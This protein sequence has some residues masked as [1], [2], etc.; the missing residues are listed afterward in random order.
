MKKFKKII[1]VV[2]AMAMT[3]AMSFGALAATGTD[4]IQ[5]TNTVKDETYN[6]YKMFDL[7]VNEDK[8]AFSYTVS[9]AWKTFFDEKGDGAKYIT[10]FNG[11]VTEI[12]DKDGVVTD[13]AKDLAKAATV[14]AKNL[15]PDKTVKATSDTVN[16][17]GLN[18]GYY[19]I[20]STLGTKAMIQTTPQASDVKINEK[21]PEDTIEK[22]V[23]E[24]STE[25]WGNKN[26][27][28]VGQ[29]VEFQSTAV[30][31]PNTRNVKIHDTMTLGLTFNKDIVIKNGET[32]LTETTDYTVAYNENNETFTVTFTDSYLN[33]LTADTTLT[34]TYSAVLNEN[35][36]VNNNITD[37]T[38]TTSIT[39]GDKQSVEDE[40]TT[41]THKFSVYKHAAGSTTNL[42]GAIFKVELGDGTVLQL[43]KLDDN[44]YRIAK[45]NADGT[46][47][48]GAVETFTTVAN[49]DIVIWGVDSDKYLLEET[50]APSGYNKL[51][52]KKEVV[53]DA[54]N[55]TRVDVENTTG[56]MLPT[57]GGMGT[58]ILYVAGAILVIAGA[59][60]LVIK[61]RHEA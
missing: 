14:F 46:F 29:T 36:V 61:K 20:T 41:T 10:V 19:L 21:N 16:F 31:H 7:K 24:D 45:K 28:Q 47:E 22:K 30:L 4:S 17:D 18:D 15:T 3:V 54:G 57:T 35:A 37:Q 55:D 32:A 34:V 11:Y 26:D 42:P 44:N 39:Y 52:D 27:A 9:E 51:A 49:G 2:A 43:I 38:N 12:K 58:T 40:T 6:L 59:A 1:A 23:K 25:E 53:V 5:V 48:T 33:G 13:D 8:S 60:V 50:E 56:N